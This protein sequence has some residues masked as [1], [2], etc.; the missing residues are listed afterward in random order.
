M[1]SKEVS[2]FPSQFGIDIH[3][4]DSKGVAMEGEKYGFSTIIISDK[5]SDWIQQI[6]MNIK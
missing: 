1:K 6:L 2:K 5:E 4:D 3:V